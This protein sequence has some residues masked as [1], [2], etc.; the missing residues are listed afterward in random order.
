MTS[1]YPGSWEPRSFAWKGGSENDAQISSEA[2]EFV[3]FAEWAFGPTGFP[4]L[5][6]LAF[7]DFS[8]QDQYERQQFLVR[9]VD[10]VPHPTR[11]RHGGSGCDDRDLNFWP[12]EPSDSSVWDR[13]SI[14]GP[15][16]LAACPGSGLIDSP[17]DW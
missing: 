1:G 16:F 4:A 14:D 3:S 10:Q 17:Y 15:E 5:Q 9:R 11:Q 7:G 12:V 13:V 8:H 6:V 2:V